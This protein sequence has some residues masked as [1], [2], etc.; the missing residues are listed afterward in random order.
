M[1]VERREEVWRWDWEGGE[2]G[3]RCGGGSERVGRRGGG[4]EVGVRG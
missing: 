4:V 1:G 3:R 2:E